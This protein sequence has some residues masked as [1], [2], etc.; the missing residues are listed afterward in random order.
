MG[1][2]N[3]GI[4][5]AVSRIERLRKRFP[6]GCRLG[7]NIGKNRDTEVDAA[8][9]DYLT[10]FRSA[11]RVADYITVNISSP[12][13]PGLRR[14]QRLEPLRELLGALRAEDGALPIAVKI[15]PDLSFHEVDD[16]VDVALETGMSGLIAT[17]TTTERPAR[18]RTGE[19]RQGG[20]SGA[21]LLGPSLRI[22]RYL[23]HA[24][25]DEPLSLIGVGG[26]CSGDDAARHLDAGADLV[27]VYSGLVFRGPALIREVDRVSEARRNSLWS[28]FAVRSDRP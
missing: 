13:T 1:F 5:A 22:V 25:R 24:L 17:N 18:S 8:T 4:E 16:L 3:G 12:N 14:L 11:R 26:I 9:A 21:P 15:A 28:G 20:L 27:Q 10:A 23:G 19:E 6:V 7:V 2:N